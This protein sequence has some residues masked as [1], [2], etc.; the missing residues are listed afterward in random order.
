MISLIFSVSHPHIWCHRT[1]VIMQDLRLSCRILI[2]AHSCLRVA[3]YLSDR[4]WLLTFFLHWLFRFH[5]YVIF[6]T[7]AVSIGRG[8]LHLLKAFSSQD[9]LFLEVVLRRWFFAAELKSIFLNNIAELI[10]KLI[11]DVILDSFLFLDFELPCPTI[12]EAEGKF[13]RF[14]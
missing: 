6:I 1:T 12:F 10:Y 5:I 4:Q 13:F 2:P 7:W 9:D 14:E 8:S 3:F 11:L